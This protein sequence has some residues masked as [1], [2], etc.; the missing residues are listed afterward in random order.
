MTHL[1]VA[2]TVA[3]L[4]LISVD[5]ACLSHLAATATATASAPR[6]TTQEAFPIAVL[7]L[8]RT[9]FGPDGT[10]SE[11]KAGI[12]RLGYTERHQEAQK[13]DGKH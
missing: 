7:I 12:P 8:R 1:L 3:S 4:T 2:V 10:D 11:W 9:V 13:T 6:G 5:R